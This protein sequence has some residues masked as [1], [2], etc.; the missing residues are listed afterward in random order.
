[1]N[2]SARVYAQTK[3]PYVI[4]IGCI[5]WTLFLST[6]R[7]D[8][9]IRQN[10]QS[11][12]ISPLYKPHLLT[13]RNFGTADHTLRNTGGTHEIYGVAQKTL[14]SGLSAVKH[15]VPNDFCGTL[16]VELSF[17]FTVW[18]PWTYQQ[19]FTVLN[20]IFKIFYIV[21]TVHFGMKLYNDLRNAQIYNLFINLLLPYMFLAFF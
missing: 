16:Y 7:I 21:K 20:N 2:N 17:T 8:S 3:F 11:P 4:K 12:K 13:H 1:M 14:D 5:W 10:F 18:Y 15:R 6:N 9:P 19:R